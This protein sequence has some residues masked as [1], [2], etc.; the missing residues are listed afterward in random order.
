MRRSTH[1]IDDGHLPVCE[2]NVWPVDMYKFRQYSLADAVEAFRQTHHPTM[3][4]E[5]EAAVIAIIELDMSTDKK[6]GCY[7]EILM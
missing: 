3:Y 7:F 2:D 1:L 4:N 5:P 6:V